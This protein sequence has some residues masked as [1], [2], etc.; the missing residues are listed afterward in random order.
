MDFIGSAGGIDDAHHVAVVAA[1]GKVAFANAFKEVELFAFETVGGATANCHALAANLDGNVKH[2]SKFGE[3]G[4]TSEFR[5][6]LHLVGTESTGI[7]LIGKRAPRKAIR[8]HNV[9]CIKCRLDDFVNHLS[10]SRIVQQELGI[11]GHDTLE[12]RVQKQF[13]NTLRNFRATGFAQSHDLVTLRFECRNQQ[14][15][16]RRLAGTVNAFEAEKILRSFQFF[17]RQPR[18]IV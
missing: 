14:V 2:N 1:G 15:N 5:Q 7:A 13:A 10:A 6:S 17:N 11:V 9:P 8:N 4:T 12:R 3:A 18:R 16:L